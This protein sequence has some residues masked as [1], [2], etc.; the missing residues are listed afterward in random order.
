[1]VAA[2][3]G[4]EVPFAVAA[5]VSVQEIACTAAVLVRMR[6]GGS[7]ALCGWKF[8]VHILATIVSAL[9]YAATPVYFL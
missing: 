9:L 5:D 2:R 7:D 6:S 4:G 1:M 3:E 8:H